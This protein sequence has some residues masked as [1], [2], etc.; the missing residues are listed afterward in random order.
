MP[1]P[2]PAANLVLPAKLVQLSLPRTQPRK[3]MASL[4]LLQEDIGRRPFR[5]KAVTTKTHLEPA[6]VCDRC[7]NQHLVKNS[8]PVGKRVAFASCKDLT[9]PECGIILFWSTDCEFCA[10]PINGGTLAYSLETEGGGE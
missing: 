10:P 5:K 7:A 1:L 8:A 9:C 3:S 6:V 2:L 4:Y